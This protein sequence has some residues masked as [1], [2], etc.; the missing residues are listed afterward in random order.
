MELEHWLAI[1]ICAGIAVLVPLVGFLWKRRKRNSLIR[2]FLAALEAPENAKWGEQFLKIKKLT[3]KIIW[4]VDNTIRSKS[5]EL[6]LEA[7]SKAVNELPALIQE[8][9]D[10][11]LPKSKRTRQSF[12]YYVSGLASYLLACQYF[13]VSFEQNDEEAAKESAKQ[14]KIAGELMDKSFGLSI[15]KKRLG[16]RIPLFRRS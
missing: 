9:N 15:G 12:I 3:D 10:L 13:K 8:L 6:E 4:G 2:Q 1:F 16:W 7:L 14:I 11:S 5:L